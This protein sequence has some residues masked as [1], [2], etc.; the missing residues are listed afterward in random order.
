MTVGEIFLESL[1]TGVI[2][3]R[4]VNWLAA[5]Q[6]NFDRPE[7]AAAIRLGRLMDQGEINLGCRLSESM[8]HHQEVLVDW[9]EP[10]GRRRHRAAA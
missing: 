10:L 1:S 9:I 7:E 5:Q 6:T 4:E 2:T 8:L 3:E